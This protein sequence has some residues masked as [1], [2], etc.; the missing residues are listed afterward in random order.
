[1][2]LSLLTSMSQPKSLILIVHLHFQILGNDFGTWTLD[3]H[4]SVSGAQGSVQAISATVVCK[5]VN[6]A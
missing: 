6:N 3:R 4:Y 2:V 5:S 1:M